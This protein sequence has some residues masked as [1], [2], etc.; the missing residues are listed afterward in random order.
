MRLDQTQLVIRERSLLELLDLALRLFSANGL[1]LLLSAG[2]LILVCMI[3]SEVLIG[4]MLT[5]L[6]DPGQVTRYL[7]TQF[8]LI[9]INAPLVTAPMITYLGQ[10]VFQ[11]RPD[12]WQV[13]RSTL[14]AWWPLLVYVVFG[15][16][17]AFAWGLV[18]LIP[19]Y[20]EY[21]TAEGWL[22]LLAGVCML[23]RAARPFI[24]EIILLERNPMRARDKQTMT[25]RRRSTALHG[26]HTGDLIGRWILTAILTVSLVLALIATL[27]CVQG[28]LLFNWNLGDWFLRLA[29]PAIMWFVVVFM[30]VVRFLTYLDTRIRREGWEV[31]LKVRAAAARWEGQFV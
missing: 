27:W 22:V 19:R 21:S 13:L 20:G 5:D 26:P 10:A 15:R 31:E 3:G 25:V 29:I 7:W 6:D 12:V 23:I 14:Q 16:G 4:W 8:L 2:P 30:H 11:E 28:T 18:L 9:S 24:C 1:P 17:I